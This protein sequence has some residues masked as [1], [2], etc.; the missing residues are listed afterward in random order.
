MEEK[1]FV[2]ECALPR[3]Y[4]SLDEWGG[5]WKGRL[6]GGEDIPEEQ[7]G[8]CGMFRL[9]GPGNVNC[10]GKGRRAGARL[11]RQARAKP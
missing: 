7:M 9:V 6:A 10:G 1:E 5:F 4:R 2:N 8:R 11:K 3:S